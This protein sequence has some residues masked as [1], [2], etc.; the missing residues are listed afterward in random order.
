[1]FETDATHLPRLIGCNGSRL[2]GANDPTPINLISQTAKEEG[3]AAH[4]M[5]MMIGTKYSTSEQ[6]IGSQA[7]NKI[8]LSQEMYDFV[9]EYLSV[10]FSRRAEHFFECDTSYTDEKQQWKINARCDNVSFDHE[11]KTLYIDEFKYGWRIV[12]PEMNWAMIA[13]AIGFCMNNGIEPVKIVFTVHQPRPYH[14]EGKTRIW[15]IDY[16]QL[17]HYFHVL[18]GTLINLSNEINSG[19]WC[20]KCPSYTKCPAARNADANAIEASEIAFDDEIENDDLAILL[21]HLRRAKS[22]L[23]STLDAFQELAEYRIKQGEIID[24]YSVN[25]SYGN[26]TWKKEFNDPDLLKL[27]T[28]FDLRSD[29]LI[30]PNQAINKG[31]SEEFVKSI[32][33]RPL[34]G[35]KLQRISADKKAQKLLNST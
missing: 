4:Y 30:T 27:M 1:M 17:M 16:N 25:E 31:V 35:T 5:A 32:T 10:V 8:I 3:I 21:D 19:P 15:E 29:K 6:L 24:N 20:V 11:T 18:H 2:M 34:T 9:D 28:T 14:F 7:P 23:N 12:E 13:H 22:Q 26:T 33:Y